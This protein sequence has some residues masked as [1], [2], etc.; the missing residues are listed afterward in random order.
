M[1][2]NVSFA[3]ANNKIGEKIMNLNIPSLRRY[4]CP[5]VAGDKEWTMK[6]VD[7]GGCAVG[8][9]VQEILDKQTSPKKQQMP[10]PEEYRK[11]IQVA[12]TKDDPAEYLHSMG[13]YKNYA[14]ALTAVNKYRRKNGI[15]RPDRVS[16]RGAAFNKEVSLSRIEK[17]F[18]NAK[19]LEE[20]IVNYLRVA[21][22]T[23][24][25]KSLSG[26]AYGWHKRYPDMVK[27]YPLMSKVPA[28]LGSSANKAKTA[29]ELLAELEGDEVSVEDFLN[30]S[31]TESEPEV[32]I[33]GDTTVTGDGRIVKTADVV[34]AAAE[35]EPTLGKKLDKAATD[36]HVEIQPTPAQ[37]VIRDEFGKKRK[38]LLAKANE[39]SR[40]IENLT[41]EA[42]G[43]MS[44]I[45]M[46]DSVAF[47]F[48]MKPKKKEE[49]A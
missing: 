24:S 23:L 49:T 40:Q 32:F 15:D 27:K 46:L 48:G 22:P 35:F 19:T 4:A 25:C 43:I 37:V 30:E 44:Q 34:E 42:E 7:C 9:R 31:S 1:V 16:N 2:A 47:M 11:R 21:T 29:I 3:E 39:I 36:A 28:Y 18:E 8:K 10:S 38:E 20:A 13:Y 33:C 12:L 6:C 41:K 26:T 45:D 14:S 17:I 5:K